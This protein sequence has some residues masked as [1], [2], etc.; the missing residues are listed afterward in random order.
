MFN[1]KC[2]KSNSFHGMQWKDIQRMRADQQSW[3]RNNSV[4]FKLSNAVAK[5]HTKHAAILLKAL[6]GQR[7]HTG[8]SSPCL[9]TLSAPQG[10]V[11][12]KRLHLPTL[13]STKI[14]KWVGSEYLSHS[15]WWGFFFFVSVLT[16]YYNHILKFIHDPVH[17]QSWRRK[18]LMI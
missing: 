17:S 14:K 5:A 8:Y 12:F 4:T 2:E 1:N 10:S 18:H 3:P 13:V 6:Q 11:S 9:Q 15:K 7:H 16:M